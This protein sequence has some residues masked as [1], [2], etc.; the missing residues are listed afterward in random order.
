MEWAALSGALWLGILTAIS[1][2]PLATNTA[3]LSYLAKHVSDPQRVLWGGTAYTLGRVF[4][5]TVLAALLVSGL[6]S[7]SAVSFFLQKHLNQLMGPILVLTGAALLG[8]LP[9]PSFSVGG[10]EKF[11]KFASSGVW[12]SFVMGAGFA[13]AFCPVSAALFFGGLLP[14]ALKENSRFLFPAVYGFGTALPVAVLAV[15]VAFGVKKA[16][17]AFNRMTSIEKWMRLATGWLFVGLGIYFT[18]KR[19]FLE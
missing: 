17:G 16:A 4:S 5:Y 15:A 6:L 19:L 9:L 13:L 1:P 8:Y 11:Q 3:A 14:L 7:V 12:G 2:C 10:G 18:I